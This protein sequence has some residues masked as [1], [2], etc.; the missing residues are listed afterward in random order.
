MRARAWAAFCSTLSRARLVAHT[1][2]SALLGLG[3]HRCYLALA[4]LA[5]RIPLLGWLPLAPGAQL[6]DF[7]VDC[8]CYFTDNIYIKSPVEGHFDFHDAERFEHEYAAVVSGLSPRARDELLS[9]IQA[10]VARRRGAASQSTLRRRQVQAAYRPLHPSLWTL[11]QEFLHEDFVALVRTAEAGDT[12]AL[13]P[14]AEGVFALPVFSA[15]F[16][17]LLC[18]ELAHF[19]ASGLP[20][21]RPNSMNAAGVLLAELGLGIYIYIYICVCV[22]VE[23]GLGVYARTHARAHGTHGTHGIHARHARTFRHM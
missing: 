19:A 22:C 15:H 1:S 16:C 21:G 3:P 17:T 23:L 14:L 5:P 7:G 8:S 20:M 6:S 12:P 10:E 18:E 11:R 4:S 13:R 9:R 2:F